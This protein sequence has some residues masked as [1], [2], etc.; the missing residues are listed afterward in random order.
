MK[1]ERAQREEAV[2]KWKH[3][4]LAIKTELDELIQR[5]YHGEGLYWR[6]EEADTDME[7]LKKEL[8]EKEEIVKALQNQLASMEQEKNKK[9]REFDIL[10]QSL[11]IMSNK[12]SSSNVRE[13]L[14]KACT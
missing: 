2:E 8:Q 14:C 11:R 5:T 12:K 3:L 1:E 7:K 13:K 6:A 4:Y 10:R 9:E